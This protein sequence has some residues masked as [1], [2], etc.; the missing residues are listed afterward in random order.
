MLE[1]SVKKEQLPAETTNNMNFNNLNPFSEKF[2]PNTSNTTN[3]SN[4]SFKHTYLYKTTFLRPPLSE[5]CFYDGSD[6][7][8]VDKTIE[9]MLPEQHPENNVTLWDESDYGKI[10]PSTD[11]IDIYICFQS[12]ENVYPKWPENLKSLK[13]DTD[14]P[15]ELLKNLPKG[16]LF[17][18]LCGMD[19]EKLKGF[20][21]P[22]QLQG[23]VLPKNFNDKLE[24]INLP[25][26][27]RLLSFLGPY[28]REIKNLPEG[29]VVLNFFNKFNNKIENYPKTLLKLRLSSNF[30]QKVD[31]LPESLIFLLLGREF[32]QEINNLP[33]YL[34]KLKIGGSF[35]Q[36]IKKMPKMLFKIYVSNEQKSPIHFPKNPEI[37]TIKKV[38]SYY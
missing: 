12:K 16:L 3:T 11:G 10:L 8:V 15:L 7:D 18:D 36:E 21:Y 38:P 29:L 17:L 31:N 26:S 32:N 19:A 20:E 9:G 25:N 1:K 22:S 23:L 6:N 14:A 24:D 5:A 35:N 2:A 13:I 37:L 4:T 34:Q 27:L 33:P 28:D 30:N